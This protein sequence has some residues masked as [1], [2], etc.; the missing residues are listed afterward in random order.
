MPINPTMINIK[1]MKIAFANLYATICSPSVCKY[2]ITS[3]LV[4]SIAIPNL[5][6]K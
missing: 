5:S 6:N 4:Q 2:G 1:D 3:S